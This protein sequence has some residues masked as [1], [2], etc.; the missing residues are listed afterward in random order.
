[1]GRIMPGN[2]ATRNGNHAAV[3]KLAA[4]GYLLGCMGSVGT[5]LCNELRRQIAWLQA[6]LALWPAGEGSASA[7][8]ELVSELEHRLGLL[9]LLTGEPLALA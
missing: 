2:L 3:G 8:D 6:A 1:M 4:A 5:R 7:R 9:A